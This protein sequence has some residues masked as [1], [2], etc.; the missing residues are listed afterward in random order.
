MAKSNEGISVRISDDIISALDEV[1]R[2]KN[3][4]RNAL[5]KYLIEQC[6]AEE[7]AIV[8]GWIQVARQGESDAN[9]CAECRNSLD[10]ERG[11]YAPLMSNGIV[12]SLHCADCATCE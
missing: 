5:I 4:S 12:G 11:V 7:T 10:W 2:R 1:A 8:L 6:I 3:I 9:E